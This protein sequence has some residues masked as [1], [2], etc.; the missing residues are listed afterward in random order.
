MKNFIRGKIGRFLMFVI[1]AVC[2]SLAAGS[3]GGSW[4]MMS[5][6]L[7]GDGIYSGSA[8]ELLDVID[9]NAVYSQSWGMWRDAMDSATVRLR[10][11]CSFEITDGFGR[12]IYRSEGFEEMSASPDARLFEY[13][14]Q[15]EYMIV[16]GIWKSTDVIVKEYI[17]SDFVFPAEHMFERSLVVF[18]IS[19]KQYLIPAAFIFAAASLLIY[20]I[21][22]YS[23]GRRPGSEELYP[24]LLEAVPFD[25]ML[26]FCGGLCLCAAMLLD[27]QPAFL[28]F[29]AGL[30]LVLPMGACLFLGVSMSLASRLKRGTLVKGTLIY[31]ICALAVCLL[32]KLLDGLR[33]ICIS[34]GGF[35][36]RIPLVSRTALM[37]LGLMILDTILSGLAFVE[38]EFFIIALAAEKLMLFS[39]AV[40]VALEL[41]KLQ[42]GATALAE[43]DMGYITD[44]SSLHGD[45]KRHG[46][47][48]NSIKAGMSKAV[49]HGIKSERMKTELLT[50]VSHDIKTP[51]TS[52]INYSSL[53]NKAEP[54]DP[55]IGEYSQVLLR[56][57][58]KLKRLLDDLVEASKAST[59]NLEIEPAPC[60]ACLFIEQALGE[61]RERLEDAGLIPVSSVPEEPVMISADGR[62]MQRVFD[63]LMGNVCKY[64]QPGTRVFMDLARENG[65]AVMRIKNTSRDQLN[66]GAEELMERFV[67]GD[68]SRSSEGNGLGLSIAKSLTELQGGSFDLSVDGDLFKVTVSFPL[69]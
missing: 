35:V 27:N 43:G 51:I 3:A 55:E 53:I 16:P 26:V 60:D 12:S 61:F 67:R 15:M 54:G 18:G 57:S 31:R 24:G 7:Y 58:E 30:V 64:S 4:I 13:A 28:I 42:L 39:G 22:M 56:Q 66:I 59:G 6:G 65:M 40:A 23:A 46:E 36:S 50:N 63:N 68:R 1:F 9:S 20:V 49:E 19:V 34:L 5:E 44:T 25:V 10:P 69:I 37:V 48:L 29:T 32:K 62:R 52:I 47:A 38:G 17:T 11:G 2:V 8:S 21:M 41:K 45:F 33:R 14:E